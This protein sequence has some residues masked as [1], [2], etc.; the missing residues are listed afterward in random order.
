EPVNP[1]LGIHAAV[2]RKRPDESHGGYYPEQKLSVFESVS[3]FTK[4][5]AFAIGR[6]HERG[7]IKE[8]FVADFTVLDRDIFPCDPD[9]LLETKPV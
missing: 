4:G 1:L 2:T 9:I 7:M 5:S 3:L 6:E 8:N